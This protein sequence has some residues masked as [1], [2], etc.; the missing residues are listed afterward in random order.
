MH[1][2]HHHAIINSFSPSDL[3]E[4]WEKKTLRLVGAFGHP[5][6]TP[7]TALRAHQED[8]DARDFE[9]L[10]GRQRKNTTNITSTSASEEINIYIYTRTS[11]GWA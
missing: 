5:I 6:P 7:L 11:H 2:S 3:Q 4:R 10:K 9:S 1:S 8:D